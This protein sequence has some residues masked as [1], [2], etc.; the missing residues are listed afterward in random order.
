MKFLEQH[1]IVHAFASGF[2]AA[3]EDI[4]NGSPVS[5]VIHLDRYR[6]CTF[7]VIKNAGDTG[8][9]TV[10]I[11]SCSDAAGT[12]AA[13]VAFKYREVTAPD[14]HGAWTDATSTGVTISAGADEIWEFRVN[15][16]GLSSTN[17]FVKCTLTEVDST[18]VD[19]GALAILTDYRYGDS[20]P[21]TAGSD[22]I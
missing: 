1:K 10:T 7:I 5:D 18:A 9:A 14:T 20:D 3:N 6:E 17:E 21:D 4:F 19:G 13:D 8:T 2:I 15:A 22:V 11:N 16:D 12:T